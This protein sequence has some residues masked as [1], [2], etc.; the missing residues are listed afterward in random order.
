VRLFPKNFKFMRSP[1]TSGLE[2]NNE[3]KRGK[4]KGWWAAIFSYLSSTE[5]PPTATFSCSYT[6][7]SLLN[8][9]S[10][11]HEHKRTLPP[12]SCFLSDH[13]WKHA[14]E[15][16]HSLSSLPCRKSGEGRMSVC[17]FTSAV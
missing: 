17:L 10:S 6:L 3:Y 2:S 12:L 11:R 16:T 7:P 14:K 13:R 1:T 9:R 8:C 15:Q 4:E 5:I